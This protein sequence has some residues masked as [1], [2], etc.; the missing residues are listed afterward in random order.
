MTRKQLADL[1][2]IAERSGTAEPGASQA[3]SELK[4][5]LEAQAGSRDLPRSG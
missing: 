1:S 2:A 3:L 4:A 5:T